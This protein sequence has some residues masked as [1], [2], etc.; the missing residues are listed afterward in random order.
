MDNERPER[1]PLTHSVVATPTDGR[2]EFVPAA[3]DPHARIAN[4]AGTSVLFALPPGGLGT[5]YVESL[6][7]YI[8]RLAAEHELSTTKLL[9][10]YV[11]EPYRLE[12]NQKEPFFH[13]SSVTEVLNGPSTTTRLVATRLAQLTWVPEALRCT[14]VDRVAGIVFQGSFRRYRAWC[15]AC[16]EADGPRAYD[17][18]LW[19]FTFVNACPIHH[20]AL[21]TQCARCHQ[22]H[23]PLQT[24]AHPLRCPR[25]TGRDD[26][27]CGAPLTMRIQ[28]LVE[29]PSVEAQIIA[30]L[31]ARI[32]RGEPVSAQHVVAGAQA[33]IATTTWVQ[34][35]R[36]AGVTHGAIAGFRTGH[37]SLARTVL[38]VIAASGEG[39]DTFLSHT[40]VR[41]LGMSA[42]GGHYGRRR[43]HADIERDL[44][45]LLAGP[46]S[47]LPTLRA[48]ARAHRTEP[49]FVVQ[50]CPESARALVTAR[51]DY[52][53]ERRAAR[54]ADLIAL[55]CRTAEQLIAETG[56]CSWR[57]LAEC[58]PHPGVLRDPQISATARRFIEDQQPKKE[59]T[60]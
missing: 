3:L 44:Q 21:Q 58:L 18:L 57:G 12:R 47:E 33:A 34:F 46:A 43:D 55:I 25:R 32:E 41:P 45:R 1:S 53:R 37:A 29:P 26:V 39:V 7:S 9:T 36:K 42:G 23:L 6:T 56:R 5:Q 14:L 16:L 54:M 2:G 50:R 15:P 19:A 35:A 8:R 31:V 22:P 27:L 20:L 59:K 17:R 51:R 52:E 38:A 28:L 48:F 30:A 60:K 4:A 24:G 49:T 13:P 11:L 40:K 10:A